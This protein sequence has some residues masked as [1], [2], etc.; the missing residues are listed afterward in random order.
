MIRI[1]FDQGVNRAIAVDKGKQI[2]ECTFSVSDKIWIIDHTF[3]EPEYGGQGIARKLVDKIVDEAR[4]AGV[5]LTATCPYAVKVF[6]D[7]KYKD[8]IA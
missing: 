4:K 8:I 3:V 6:K 5:R 1:K 7:Y 2:G